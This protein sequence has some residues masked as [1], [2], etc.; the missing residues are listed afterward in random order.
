MDTAFCFY[1]SC[2]ISFSARSRQEPP[3]TTSTKTQRCNFSVEIE[4]PNHMCLRTRYILHAYTVYNMCIKR[5]K[6]CNLSYYINFVTYTIFGRS[7]KH[8]AGNSRAYKSSP[9]TKRLTKS[10]NVYPTS[11]TKQSYST[12]VQTAAGLHM[13]VTLAKKP[14]QAE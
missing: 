13:L 5:T 12:L 11:Q 6:C 4:F 14:G 1:P 3:C 2:D 10:R 9:N 8:K 7:V